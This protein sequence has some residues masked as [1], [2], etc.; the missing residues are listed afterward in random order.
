MLSK[1]ITEAGYEVLTAANGQEALE[2]IRTQSPDVIIL[3]VMMPKMDGFTVLEEIRKHPDARKWQPVIM[4]SGHTGLED[5]QK[6]FDLEADHYIT[7]PC[8]IED[9]QKIMEL[10]IRLV[11]RRQKEE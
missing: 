2:V 9:I 5:L 11:P 8:K 7:K 4:V 3:D 1:K 6:A 10:M